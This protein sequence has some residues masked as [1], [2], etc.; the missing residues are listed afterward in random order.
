[1][2]V[3]WASWYGV[4]AFSR[5]TAWN[6]PECQVLKATCGV[7]VGL[8]AEYDVFGGFHVS[9][10]AG[11]FSGSLYSPWTVGTFGLEMR[12]IRVQPQGHPWPAA[13]KLP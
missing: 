7:S 6:P 9:H 13:V 3:N 2:G 12:I 8:C 1:L 5:L 10:V 11:S 4:R